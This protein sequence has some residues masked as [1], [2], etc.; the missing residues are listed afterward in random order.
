M[1]CELRWARLFDLFD[2]LE[3][4]GEDMG[5]GLALVEHIDEMQSGKI[6]VESD[7]KGAPVL[8]LLVEAYWTIRLLNCRVMGVQP[9]SLTDLG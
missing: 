8:V 2:R 5:I 4:Q 6:W 7:M 1:S 9:A 3:A